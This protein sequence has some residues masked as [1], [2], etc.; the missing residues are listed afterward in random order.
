MLENRHNV[1]TMEAAPQVPSISSCIV[2]YTPVKLEF[3]SMAIPP[4][5]LD[6]RH[7]ACF[8]AKKRMVSEAAGSLG[9][10]VSKKTPTMVIGAFK[11]IG[12]EFAVKSL[13]QVAA[14]TTAKPKKKQPKRTKNPK[15][16]GQPIKIPIKSLEKTKQKKAAVVAPTKK[17]PHRQKQ[18]KSPAHGERNGE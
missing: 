1:K 14:E 3:K 4:D 10:M 5:D 6:E 17:K 13:A 15:K 16:A 18:K 9:S 2:P 7:D 8:E 11:S 12:L